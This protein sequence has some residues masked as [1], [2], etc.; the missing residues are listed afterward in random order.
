MKAI[1][2]IITLMES[3]LTSIMTVPD[4]RVIGNMTNNTVVEQKLG[5]MGLRTKG[6]L[7][8]VRRL[9][10][11]PS[12]G[13]MA[14]LTQ[15]RQ[16]MIVYK[17]MERIVLPTVESTMDNFSKIRCMDM[18]SLRGQMAEDSRECMSNQ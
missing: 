14:P 8:K 4:M 13:Q 9:A 6:S 18:A 2:S 17:A 12:C 11:G 5:L 10:K 3:E 16:K 15:V 1:G 7:N